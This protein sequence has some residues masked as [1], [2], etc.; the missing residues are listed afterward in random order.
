MPAFKISKQQ[1]F[2]LLILIFFIG[3]I[4][5]LLYFNQIS[6]GY[7]QARDAFEAVSIWTTDHYKLVGP[8]SDIPG[9]HHGVLYWYIISPF[10]YFSKGDPRVGKAFLT[11][12]N[13]SGIY[14]IYFFSQKLFK[15]KKISLLSAF[16]YAISFETVNY[17]RWSSNPT[18]AIFSIPIFFY[19]LW[20]II[21]KNLYGLPIMV[22]SW[23]ISFQSEFF[24]IYHLAFIA[25]GIVYA[26]FVNKQTIKLTK[27]SLLL[28]FLSLL[29]LSPYLASEWKFKFRTTKA[30]FGFFRKSQSFSLHLLGIKLS[31]FINSLISNIRYN[32]AD[33][34][35]ILTTIIFW[36]IITLLIFY[37]AKKKQFKKEIIFLSIWFLSPGPLYLFER[38]NAY[39][40]NIGNLYPLII[41]SAFFI[42][43]LTENVSRKLRNLLLTIVIVSVFISNIHLILKNNYKGEVLLSVQNGLTL[44]DE[45]RVVDWAYQESKGKFFAINTVTNPL[46]INT[47][48]AYLFDWYG[49][50]KY[51]YMPVWLGYPQIAVFGSQ[52]KFAAVKVEKGMPFYLIFEPTAGIPDTYIKAYPI[53]EN[54]RSK[55]IKTK[56]FG[57]FII[58]KRIIIE[59]RAFSTDDLLYIINHNLYT[60]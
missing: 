37:I 32:I 35:I 25:A 10:Y 7:D 2:I 6:F 31:K 44:S 54:R 14:I 48:W 34:N 56:K 28:Y 17:A 53:L 12:I 51:K 38:S 58:E 16:I 24:L 47:T 8:S 30:L 49:K 19:G 27:K 9:V 13:I 42:I 43:S 1:T 3:L 41:L 57:D 60:Q 50:R 21:D 23:T 55:L 18:L 4:L 22:F 52:I 11:L 29:A 46:F 15:N 33:F 26:V 39:F 5:R 45:M 36:I 40:L 20:M 59:D